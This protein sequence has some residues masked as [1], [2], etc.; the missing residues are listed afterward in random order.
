LTSYDCVVAARRA[1][2]GHLEGAGYTLA[3]VERA[4][5]VDDEAEEDDEPELD[6]AGALVG[7][8]A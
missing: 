8:G 1:Y 6:E 4:L 2:L 7:D 5:L 3:D